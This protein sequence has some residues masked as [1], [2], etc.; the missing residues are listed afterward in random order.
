[1]KTQHAR[2]RAA[3]APVVTREIAVYDD[4]MPILAAFVWGTVV[5]TSGGALKASCD[6]TEKGELMLW[7][8]I[9]SKNHEGA[10]FEG[11]KCAASEFVAVGRAL[12][13]LGQAV[14][15]EQKVA[16]QRLV[17]W[18]ARYDAALKPIKLTASGA[19]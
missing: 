1:M 11:E 17:E 15:A 19:R 6:L 3:T 8:S 5:Q 14:E 2:P 13:L 12:A 4:G 18:R 16:A 9:E 10:L 7:A